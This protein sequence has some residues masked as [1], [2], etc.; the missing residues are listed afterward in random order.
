MKNKERS[1]VSIFL[2][3]QKIFFLILNSGPKMVSPVVNSRFWHGL[4]IVRPH[5]Q[6]LFS[7]PVVK[8]F[9]ELI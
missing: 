8:G 3:F 5:C 9:S 4:K 1:S 7:T 2:E 6:H